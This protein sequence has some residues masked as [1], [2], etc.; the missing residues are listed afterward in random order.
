MS[1]EIRSD[2]AVS[3]QVGVTHGHP[4]PLQNLSS[5]SGQADRINGEYRRRGLSCA[6]ILRTL[7]V[8]GTSP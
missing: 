8:N 6:M 3:D 1:P 4:Q 2:Q 7:C 5:E